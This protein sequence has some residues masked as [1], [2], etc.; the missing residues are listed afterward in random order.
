MVP[1]RRIRLAC[2]Y[3]LVNSNGR[4]ICDIIGSLLC[5]GLLNVRDSLP[6]ALDDLS[7]LSNYVS[8][9]GG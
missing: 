4:Y 6:L 7:A 5:R 9:L 1:H 2:C 8:E 3:R